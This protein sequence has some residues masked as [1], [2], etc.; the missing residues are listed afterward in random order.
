MGCQSVLLLVALGVFGIG[1]IVGII[2]I[3]VVLEGKSLS[4]FSMFL[5]TCWCNASKSKGACVEVAPSRYM[6]G[7]GSKS[8]RGAA[9]FVVAADRCGSWR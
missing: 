4:R 3:F 6:V 8:E 1:G 9:G 2:V 5:R 7:G